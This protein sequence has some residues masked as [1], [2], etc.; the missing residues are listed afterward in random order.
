MV[1][2]IS[3]GKIANIG[4]K[5]VLSGSNSGIDSEALITSLTTARRAPAVTIETKQK[6]LAS[7]STAFATLKTL[8]AKFQD[9]ADLLRNTP[10]VTTD[11]KNLFKYRTTTLTAQ[12][13]NL[14]GD[15]YLSAS[16]AAGATPQSYTINEISQLARAKKQQTNAFTLTSPNDA[17]VTID[18]A[19]STFKAAQFTLKGQTVTLEIGDSL[20]TVA[21]KINAVS[22]S[23]GIKANILQTSPGQYSMVFTA[24]KTGTDADFDLSNASTVTDTNGALSNITFGN[25]QLAQNAKF[26]V[27]NIA[28][29]RQSNVISDVVTGTTLTLKQVTGTG[30][31][32][33]FGIVPDTANIKTGITN[34]LDDYNNLR[35]F[36][37]E[38]TARNTDG[39]PKS[40]KAAD[41]T[42]TV[43]AVL[44]NDPTLRTIMNNM[45]NVVSGIVGGVAS[46]NL[47]KIADVGVTF[48]DFAGNDTTPATKNILTLDDTKLTNALTNN[49]DQVAN[50]FQFNSSTTVP[51][52]QVFKRTNDLN[53][54][55][56]TVNLDPVAK[57][58]TASYTKAGDLT[59]TTV[60][61]KSS[62]INGGGVSLV[63]PDGSPIE[64]LQMIFAGTAA[65]TGS[66]HVSQGLADR[67][68]N[69]LDTAT[70]TTDGTLT[71][72]VKEITDKTTRA[73]DEITKIDDAVAT[74]RD[75]LV[76]KF[77]QLE[78]ALASINTIL[79]TLNANDA[80]RTANNG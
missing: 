29:E 37:A 61:L 57:T 30:V 45:S 12:G 51:D 76:A 66:V 50:L 48:S 14:T 32:V 20:Q 74:Y 6:T 39:S 52:L 21:N 44:A 79:Q 47:N 22:T 13:T 4:G 38:Q 71:N 1:S 5:T 17:A 23:T 33:D 42:V 56:F 60:T 46:G 28:V 40:T 58:Y 70:N 24:D 65:A 19:G 26:K 73:T 67:M 53:L 36:Y 27:D 72:A 11:D 15:A 64:G 62:E 34:F 31:S 18:G 63:G 35:T 2:S 54:T 55:D 75:Q 49:F 68:Y 69:A 43:T 77:S 59:P 25:V 3:F 41:G 78:S 8:L 10:D 16:V 7:Q 80:A 9:S